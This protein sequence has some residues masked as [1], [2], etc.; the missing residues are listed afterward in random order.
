MKWPHTSKQVTRA[1]YSILV[2][3]E[4]I[5]TFFGTLGDFAVVCELRTMPA[6]DDGK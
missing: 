2:G 1:F 5:H 6:A 4:Q 3:G